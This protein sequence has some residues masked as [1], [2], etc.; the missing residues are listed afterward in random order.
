[1]TIKEVC[2][3]EKLNENYKSDCFPDIILSVKFADYFRYCPY[4][5]KE[6]KVK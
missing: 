6:I 5:G 4:C 2:N 3:W 1:M